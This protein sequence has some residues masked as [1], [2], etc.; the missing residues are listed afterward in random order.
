MSGVVDLYSGC[1]GLS[2]GASAAGLAPTLSIDIDPILTSSY[3]ENHPDTQ[4]LVADTNEVSA[5]SIQDLVGG[6]PMGVIG[7]PPCQGFSEIG[8]KAPEDPRNKLLL[9]FFQLVSDLRPAFFLMEN[10]P[11]LL[12]ERNMPML[13]DGLCLVAGH[14][15]ILQP[16]I[17]N[18]SDFGAAT[19]RRRVVVIGTDPEQM[20][21]VDDFFFSPLLD[22]KTTVR[23]AIGGLPKP[24]NTNVSFQC[25][26]DYGRKLD[27]LFPPR[28]PEYRKNHPVTGFELTS[29]SEQVRARFEVTLPG[30]TEKKSR[31]AKLDWDAQ[32]P[33][34]RAGTGSD[35]GSYQ[36]ARPIHPTEPRVITVREAARL[37]GF[38]DW[39]RFHPTKWH[40][41]RMI[42]NSV[43]PIFA[44][45]LIARVAKA[46][47][48][49]GTKAA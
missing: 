43:S 22:P 47:P 44:R 1:G 18:A 32:A 15:N 17:L 9:R 42:G 48:L 46:L 29:H 21:T 49:E 14:Y 28:D 2:L 37:Q 34:L 40:S 33:T 31:Y 25:G 4:L 7:G 27:W 11:G 24:D 45:E 30:E 26:C 38:P 13:E 41:H 6:R 8:R 10:V 39:Y 20:Q 3:R 5:E 12:H 35:R 16:T 23:T 36:A 19:T